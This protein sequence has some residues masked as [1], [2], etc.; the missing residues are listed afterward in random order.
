M[1]K[2]LSLVRSGCE[3]YNMI[4]EGDKI[5]V[6]LSGGKDSV[7]LLVSLS[8]LRR[9][10]PNSFSL[11]AIT[12][13]PRFNGKDTDYSELEE[14]CNRLSIPYIIKRTQL[15]DVIFN[16]REEKNPCSLCAK[17]R[18]GALHDAAKEAGCNKIALGHHM[19]DAAETFMMN[20][21]NGG[22]IGSF[23]PVTYLS[24]KDIHMIRPM[25]FVREKD[26]ARVVRKL[27]LPTVKSN[28]P[29]DGNTERQQIKEFIASLESK[30]GDLPPKILGAMQ[31]GSISGY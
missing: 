12:L 31:R 16:I 22:N 15:G 25:I 18:R 11:T 6:G 17:M 20:L 14:L 8:E 26:A 5:A 24:R 23:R 2:L 13:D 30:Y 28:C 7:A 27:N 10:Y 29:A 9:F 4:E 1:Q 3:H 21:L 19:D